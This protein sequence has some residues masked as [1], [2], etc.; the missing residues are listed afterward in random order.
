MSGYFFRTIETNGEYVVVVAHDG[1]G[2]NHL[3]VYN[4]TLE[5][6]AEK[7]VVIK[8][9]DYSINTSTLM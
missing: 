4:S 5:L 2:K 8:K 1:N 9:T 7:M 3:F 6:L